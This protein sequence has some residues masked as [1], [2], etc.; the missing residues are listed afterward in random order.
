MALGG[1]TPDNILEVKDF[2]FGGAV[3]LGDLWGKFD[4]CSDQ[5]YLSSD[6]TLQEAEKNGGL[7][8]TTTDKI[9]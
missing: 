3:V 8:E 7:N 5:D 4:A 9:K 6:R 2:G 1:I